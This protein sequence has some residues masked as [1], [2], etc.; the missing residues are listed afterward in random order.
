MLKRDLFHSTNFEEEYRL[1]TSISPCV[2][3]LRFDCAASRSAA[4]AM[5]PHRRN[6]P[7]GLPGF[8]GVRWRLYNTWAP[9]LTAGGERIWL[10]TFNNPEEALHAYDATYRRFGHE[11]DYLNFPEVQSQEEAEF[12]AP[13]PNLHTRQEQARHECAQIKLNISEDDERRM[14]EWRCL[15]PRM[16]QE[17]RLFGPR[18]RRHGRRGGG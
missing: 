16:W 13:P 10:G 3:T 14:A 1:Q 4:D 12:L 11:R 5:P 7:I 15:H 8:H 6:H 17:R 9:E 18:R 2:C